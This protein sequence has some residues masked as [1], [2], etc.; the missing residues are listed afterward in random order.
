MLSSFFSVWDWYVSSLLCY[1]F[2][3][4]FFLSFPLSLSPTTVVKWSLN[5]REISRGKISGSRETLATASFVS[6]V[7]RL[8]P[9]AVVVVVVEADS[10]HQWQFAGFKNPLSTRIELWY[11]LLLLPSGHHSFSLCDGSIIYPEILMHLMRLDF[12]LSPLHFVFFFV[13]PR[14]VCSRVHRRCR[15]VLRSRSA[16]TGSWLSCGSWSTGFPDVSG[17]SGRKKKQKQTLKWSHLFSPPSK[18]ERKN[19]VF[20]LKE[21]KNNMVSWRRKRRRK[22]VIRQGIVRTHYGPHLSVKSKN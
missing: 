10:L 19:P 2:L 21:E 3:S 18:K 11:H 9:L 20:N 17:C 16:S 14:A 12:S 13:L 22:K 7:R 5:S 1:F 8:F 15:R 6:F 4:F